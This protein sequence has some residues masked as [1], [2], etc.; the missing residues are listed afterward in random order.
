MGELQAGAARADITPPVGIPLAG[1][2]RPRPAEGIDTPLMV[3]ALVLDDGAIRL[4][5]VAVDLIAMEAGDCDDAKRRIHDLTGIRP[6]QVLVAASHTHEAPYPCPLLGVDTGADPAYMARVRDAIVE[7]V[8]AATG[9][10]A[11]AQAGAA[12]THVPGLGGNRRLLRS[13]NDVVNAWTVTAEEQ[14]TLPQAGPVDDELVLYAVR[15][16]SGEPM[17]MLWNYPLHAHAF[18]AP[19][20]SADYPF[21]AM[22]L[23]RE[24]LGADV[25]SVFTAGACG[26]INRPIDVE[27]QTVADRLSEGLVSLYENMDFSSETSLRTTVRHIEAPLRDFSVFQQEEIARK[28]PDVLEI[29]RA[30]WQALRRAREREVSTVLQAVAL[31]DLALACVPGEYFTSLGLS[32]KERSPF[33]LTAVVE[34]ANDYVGYIPTDA[35]YDQGG[36]ELIN[37]RSSKVA[38]GAGESIADDLVQML[39]ELSEESSE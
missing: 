17:A 33:P 38:R 36:Y 21:F 10:L 23:V 5:V 4:T 26:D 35:A 14:R 37:V 25:V 6:D 9:S 31:G 8:L 3:H 34:L 15:A 24:A 12:S 19:R 22:Q 28:Q 32:I 1:G 16:Q 13:P 11:P 7:A 2:W 39:N 20:V 18:A 29:A 30:E 27:S